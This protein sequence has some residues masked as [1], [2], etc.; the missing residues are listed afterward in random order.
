MKM[1]PE[2][3]NKISKIVGEEMVNEQDNKLIDDLQDRFQKLKLNLQTR[4][5][6]AKSLSI[7]EKKAM[8]WK[9]V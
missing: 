4:K 5:R 8:N 7:D 3:I 1:N 9:T 6:I 2:Q